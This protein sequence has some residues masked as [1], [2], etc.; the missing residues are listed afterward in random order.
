MDRLVTSPS[1][2]QATAAGNNWAIA[3]RS[4]D[5]GL[6]GGSALR[7]A[8]TLATPANV[9]GSAQTSAL[10]P[11]RPISSAGPRCHRRLTSRLSARLNRPT[12]SEGPWNS[13]SF[14][15]SAA[16]LVSAVPCPLAVIPSR[17]GNWPITITSAAPQVKPSSTECETKFTSTPKRSRP[18]SHWNSPA[19]KVSRSAYWMNCGLPGGASGAM[20][21]NKTTE[22][23]AVGPPT[24]CFDEPHRQAISTGSIAAYRPYSA[25]SPAISA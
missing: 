23:A 21:V 2:P 8:A 15:H 10:A 4:N 19:R 24:M 17:Y 5:N 9:E 22:M 25:G 11:N 1:M 12:N 6:S 3:E 18:S 14:H 16:A 20:A 13:A 7:K